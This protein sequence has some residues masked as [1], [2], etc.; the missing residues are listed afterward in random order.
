LF[1]RTIDTHA[2]RLRKKL[3]LDG[4]HGMVLSSVYGQG[5]RLDTI[6]SN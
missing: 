3:G 5:Y 2:S 6:R 4:Q 1:T